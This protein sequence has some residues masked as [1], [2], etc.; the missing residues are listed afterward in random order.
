MQRTLSGKP[1]KLQKKDYNLTHADFLPKTENKL[2]KGIFLLTL[3]VKW[4]SG[5][6]K[7]VHSVVT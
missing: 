4:E 2:R 5:M 7:V 1:G 6:S 3:A